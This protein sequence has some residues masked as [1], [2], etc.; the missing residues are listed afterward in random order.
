MQN[1]RKVIRKQLIK[2]MIFNI[3]LFTI[4]FSFFSLIIFYQ[5]NKYM[6]TSVD[7]QLEE[8]KG[9][10]SEITK[11]N[12]PIDFKKN[13][14]SDNS[15]T[16]PEIGISFNEENKKKGPEVFLIDDPNNNN[17]I[18]TQ[19][20]LEKNNEE[21]TSSTSSSKNE[22][23]VEIEEIKKEVEMR[24]GK[25]GNLRVLAILRDEDGE[26]LGTSYRSDLFGDFISSISFNKE[27][28]NKIYDISINSEIFYRATVVEIESSS[29]EK[30]YIDLLINTNSEKEMLDRFKKTLIIATSA[31][32]LI[33]IFISYYLA[34]KSIK[35]IVKAYEKQSEFIQNASHELRTPLTIIQAK[36]EMLLQS[37]NSKI[38][39]KSQDIALTLNETRRL[40]K[41]VSELM[42][43]ARDDANRSAFNKQKT[44]INNLVKEVT[45]PYKE[46]AAIQEKELKIKSEC[47]KELEV[48]RNK[49]KQLIVILLDNALKYTEQGDSIE[50]EVKNQDDK[51][52]LN[53]KDT[54][55]G[56]SDEALKHIFERFYRE[57]KA[58]SREKGG[59]GLGL[60]IAQT[61][62][63]GHG[64]SIRIV[65]NQPK[66]II[67]Q[68]RF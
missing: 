68:V 5:V 56:I 66:G 64:G 62:V 52:F 12:P 38:I 18:D 45:I 40:S 48:D 14:P 46:M 47:N 15:N 9:K 7:S 41:M 32:I 35:P 10:L 60:S 6:Y 16:I 25:V 59:S 30:Y 4:L 50:I 36:Q 2:N 11:E 34:N 51:L 37:P 57:D 55:I 1:G 65:H 39:D 27:N 8:T 33:S 23:D 24:F 31:G 28:V 19:E 42:E 43:L 63:K 67:V 44:N 22:L 49:F 29:G 13:R 54:G 26:I 20:V 58:R 61:I 3:I 17:S 21:K 53:V